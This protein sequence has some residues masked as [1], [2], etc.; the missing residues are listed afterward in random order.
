METLPTV[1]VEYNDALSSIRM[2]WQNQVINTDVQ[3]AFEAINTYLQASDKPLYVI[4]DIRSNPTFP[5]TATLNGALFGPYR[6][7]MLKEW[8]I[9]GTNPVARIIERTL[10]SVTGRSNVLWFDADDEVIDYLQKQQA[11]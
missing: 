11:A 7:P 3:N 2:T 1:T 8:L 9:L 10:K 4:V 6:S 5:I